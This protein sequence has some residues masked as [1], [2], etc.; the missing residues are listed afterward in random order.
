MQQ[1]GQSGSLFQ[2]RP[3]GVLLVS[4]HRVEP[5]HTCVA[6]RQAYGPCW[7]HTRDHSRALDNC[8]ANMT[9]SHVRQV[10]HCSVALTRPDCSSMHMT[11][12][13]LRLSSQNK[14]RK[15]CQGGGKQVGYT[16]AQP[17]Q[18]SCCPCHCPSP[19]WQQFW[20][21][22]AEL[23]PGAAGGRAP[24]TSIANSDSQWAGVAP[25]AKLT[26]VPSRYPAGACVILASSF[27]QP[28]CERT[29]VKQP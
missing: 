12:N 29:S 14:R 16:G 4:M 22:C 9:H 6:D 15:Q 1:A 28:P 26:R 10:T 19:C 8:F 7:S 17:I 21:E 13:S 3:L 25:P 20:G 27:L 18:R 24:S 23:L 11:V 2:T 5:Q